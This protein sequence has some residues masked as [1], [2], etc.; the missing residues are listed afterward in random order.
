[1]TQQ[2]LIRLLKIEKMEDNSFTY[3]DLAEMLDMKTGSFY[4]WL[5]GAF[6]MSDS[7]L[8]QL[9]DWLYDRITDQSNLGEEKEI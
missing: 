6:H 8:K 5:N 7:K 1:M 4:N 2:K 9:Q 3:G